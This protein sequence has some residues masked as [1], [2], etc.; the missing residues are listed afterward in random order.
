MKK[1]IMIILVFA[2]LV[3]CGKTENS[4]KTNEEDTGQGITSDGQETEAAIEDKVQKST[5]TFPSKDGLTITADTYIIDDTSDFILVYHQAEGSRGEY[6]ETAY[7]FNALGYNVMAVD[8]RS[9][10]LVND[11]KNETARRAK[12]EAYANTA[13]DAGLDVQASIEYV[14]D[15]YD[16]EN[17]FLLGSSYSAALVLVVAPEYQDDLSGVLAFSPN[18]SLQWQGKKVK[19]NIQ[20]LSLPVFLTCAKSETVRTDFLNEFITCE[21]KTYFV[22]EGRGRHGASNLWESAKDHQEYWTAVTEF[23]QGL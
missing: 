1:I 4:H 17:L 11:V 3:G 14:R 9:G 20:D 18:I 10:L 2:L 12:E 23:L 15:T 22:P 5:I 19:E 8:L 21:E 16:Y 7:D 13:S 6:L